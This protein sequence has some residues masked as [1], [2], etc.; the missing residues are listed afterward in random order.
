MVKDGNNLLIRIE[1][2]GV[3]RGTT[4]RGAFNVAIRSNGKRLLEEKCQALLV[5]EAEHSIVFSYPWDAFQNVPRYQFMREEGGVYLA[6]F[7]LHI[8]VE[9]LIVIRWLWGFFE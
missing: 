1:V 8:R 7:V 4:V 6:D 2:Q 5:T 9:G 3:K